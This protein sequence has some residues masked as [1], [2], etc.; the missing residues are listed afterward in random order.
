M[1]GVATLLIAALSATCITGCSVVLSFFAPFD[2]AYGTPLATVSYVP[3]DG[4]TAVSKGSGNVLAN[5]AVSY[6]SGHSGSSQ[7][8]AGLVFDPGAFNSNIFQALTIDFPALSASST[9]S[10]WYKPPDITRFNSFWF[11]LETSAR[12]TI[13]TLL[14]STRVGTSD[15]SGSIVSDS[16]KITFSGS[17]GSWRHVVLTVDQAGTL[18]VY[19]EGSLEAAMSFA[20]LFSGGTRISVGFETAANV[21][22]SGPTVGLE[23]DDL[24]VFS[25]VAT[26]TDVNDLYLGRYQY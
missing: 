10:F 14:T 1:A 15:W 6:V 3:F 12:V 17:D 11:Y 23:V 25:G 19:T 24:A 7:S 8:A 2:A 16:N 4:S 22:F 18:R 13:G 21:T 5:T 20:D 9:I 26:N